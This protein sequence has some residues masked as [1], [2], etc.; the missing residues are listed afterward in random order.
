MG[1]I[2]LRELD[3]GKNVLITITEVDASGNMQLADI[4]VSVYP[5]KELKKILGFLSKNIYKF[6]QELNKRMKMRPVPKINFY[7]DVRT[8]GA[9]NVEELLEKI[10]REQ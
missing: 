4:K 8:R 5:E 3:F 1:K 9:A 10:K 7:A 2:F 6:Q